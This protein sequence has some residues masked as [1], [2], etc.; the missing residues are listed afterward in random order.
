MATV[1]PYSTANG[2]R[3]YRVRYRT[4]DRRQ[5]DKRGFRT[6]R[7]ADAFAATVEVSKLRG[8]FVPA[9][10]G[11]VTV[12]DLVAAWRARR[13]GVKPKTLAAEAN[14]FDNH[15]LPRWAGVYAVD[16]RFTDVQAWVAQMATT[17]GATLVRQA[18][19]ALS[20][21]LQ[22]EVR[23]GRLAKNPA[24]GVALPRATPKPRR[25]LSHQQVDALAA[26]AGDLGPVLLLLAY[27]GLR[28]GEMAALRVRRVD[29]LRRR[30][31]VAENV[32]D[33]NGKLLWG[34]PKTHEARSV[35]FPAFLVPL[36]SGVMAGRG[37]EDL[38]FVGERGGTLR[39]NSVRRRQFL[40][41]VRVAGTAVSQLQSA[42]RMPAR[43]RTG[44]FN[45]ATAAA[46]S[47]WQ[48]EH[49]LP[50]TGRGDRATWA[51]LAAAWDAPML[52]AYAVVDVGP[53]LADF[54]TMTLHDLRHT[55]AS[56][57]ISSGANVKAVQR[58]LGHKSAA[59]T[60]DTYADLFDDDLDAVATALDT[61][62]SDAVVGKVWAAASGGGETRRA[63]T[64]V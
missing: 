45:D 5:T 48:G 31:E 62:R 28:W 44:V 64:G 4:P 29:M 10:A 16:V 52:E 57:A 18:Y 54:P 3:R 32:V 53:G 60:L 47:R 25:Y 61:A 35:P 20:R 7:D 21:V 40:P 42:L 37:R 33:V 30:V 13:S 1:E 19:Y 46:A 27:T 14:A 11:R 51:S 2:E 26:A 22:D 12:R 36:L 17:G 38:V 6:K 55:A 63:P 58:M 50:V 56:L 23:D 34:T 41:A 8:E 59:M 49:G 15:V 24:V 43:E 39:H 9:S